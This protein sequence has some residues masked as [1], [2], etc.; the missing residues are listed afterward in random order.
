MGE[1]TD[2][3][4]LQDNQGIVLPPQSLKKH[5]VSLCGNVFKRAKWALAPDGKIVNPAKEYLPKER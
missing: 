1:Y 4:T 5:Q 3:S 2:V